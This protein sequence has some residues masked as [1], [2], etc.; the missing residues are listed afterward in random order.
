MMHA[1]TLIKRNPTIALAYGLAIAMVI[2]VSILRPG[3]GSRTHLISLA[4]EASVI[5]LIALGQTVVII[6][7]GID[8]SIPWVLNSAAILMTVLTV[9]R[10]DRMIWAIPLVL[11]A[12]AAVGLVNGLAIAYLEITPVIMTL[13]MN[14]ILLGVMAGVASGGLNIGYQNGA[15]PHFILGLARDRILGLPAVVWVWVGFIV[16]A[17]IGFSLSGL[18][19]QIYAVG[20]NATA[21]T[22][23]GINARRVKVF[24]YVISAMTSAVAGIILAGK[25]GR[26]YLGMGDPF[27]FQSVA[28]VVIGGASILGGSGHY[29]GTVAGALILAVLTALLPI[30]K[31]PAAAQN[32]IYGLVVLATV[33]LAGLSRHEG[34]TGS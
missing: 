7:G 17:S 22:Y 6:S 5:G 2:V 10:D 15:P 26:A 20:S 24:V 31:L 30:F 27:L 32:I 19:R 29:L 11:L 28:A 16:V 9:G 18:G 23:S 12:A 4:I 1:P 34:D 3:F 21:A 13:A 25:F 14:G 8:L 33:Y